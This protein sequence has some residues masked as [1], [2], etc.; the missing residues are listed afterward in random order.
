MPHSKREG[1]N[2]DFTLTRGLNATGIAINGAKLHA[3]NKDECIL[4]VLH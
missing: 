1:Q 3:M 4:I 2:R